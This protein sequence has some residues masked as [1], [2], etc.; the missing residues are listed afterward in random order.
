MPVRREYDQNQQGQQGDAELWPRHL[1]F[2]PSLYAPSLRGDAVICLSS[3]TSGH[4][5]GD[6][7]RRS[8]HGTHGD[9]ADNCSTDRCRGRSGIPRRTATMPGAARAPEH[10]CLQDS[11]AMPGSGLHQR[12]ADGLHYAALTAG[13]R[14]PQAASATYSIRYYHMARDD[15]IWFPAERIWAYCT[16]SQPTTPKATRPL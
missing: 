5:A 2:A 9:A 1:T 12:T 14:P 11:G 16:S 8:Q 4:E 15:I 6:R 3:H 10:V 13:D 7:P